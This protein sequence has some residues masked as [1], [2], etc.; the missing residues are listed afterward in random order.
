MTKKNEILKKLGITAILLVCFGGYGLYKAKAYLE[1]P[2]IFIDYPKN[3]QIVN[4]SFVEI[5]GMSLNVSS[6]YLNGR[7]IFPDKSG[8]FN[9][10]L[11]LAPGY[12]IIELKGNDKFGRET[13]EELEI[14]YKK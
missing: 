14:I 13:K 12:N 4:Q 2:R 11:L 5:S 9:D 10:G 7:Q 3:G 1:G 6:L 8:N